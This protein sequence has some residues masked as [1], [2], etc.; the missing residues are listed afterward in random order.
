MEIDASN[1]REVQR[2]LDAV[3][4]PHMRWTVDAG[5]VVYAASLASRRLD[6]YLPHMRRNG[7]IVS[8]N[9]HANEI[10]KEYQGRDCKSTLLLLVWKI[11]RFY[12]ADVIRYDAHSPLIL[13][14]NTRDYA[15]QIAE[16]VKL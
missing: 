3:Q 4:K 13:W 11:D 16:H 1:K 15:H 14:H 2:A 9:V 6:T 12:L 7:V 8:L 10:E 5:D